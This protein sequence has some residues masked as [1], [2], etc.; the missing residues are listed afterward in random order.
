MEQSVEA[1][2]AK[3]TVATLGC[4]LVWV[5]GLVLVP[6]ARADSQVRIVRLSLVEGSVQIDRA[7]GQ[8]FEKAIMNMPLAQGMA[9]ATGDDSRAE[10]EFEDGSTLRLAPGTQVAFPQLG[11]RS[12]G[13][14]FTTVQVDQGLAYFN[15]RHKGDDDFRVGFVGREI[16]VNRNVHFRLDLA[17]GNPELAVFK[18]ELEVEGPQE[19]AKVKKN[20]TLTLDVSDFARSD[21][22]KSIVAE[23]YDSWDA[24]R[25]NYAAQYASNSYSRSPYYYGVSDL[26]YYGAWSTW[27]GY[28]VVWRPFGVGYG[29]DPFFNGAW[30][31][32]PGFG[33]TWVSTYPWGW[34][35]YRYGSWVYVTNYGWGWRPGGW[36]TWYTVP[37]VYNPPPFYHG[38]KPPPAVTI[39]TARPVAP[40]P[41]IIVDRGVGIIR[42]PRKFSDDFVPRTGV[43]T[44]RAPGVVAVPAAPLHRPPVRTITPAPGT[45]LAAPGSP[46]P[47]RHSDMRSRKVDQDFSPKWGARP[48]VQRS[49]PPVRTQPSAPSVQRS[50]PRMERS[51]PAP[52]MERSAPRM[53][54]SAPA[55]RITAPSGGRSGGG[56]ISR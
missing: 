45:G 53:E 47:M 36:R 55:P 5:A 17:S 19:H 39:V 21:L 14:R 29:W 28:G 13:A 22:A 50:A 9:I 31:W 56:R 10:V 35:P 42:G 25:L 54:R 52:R 7:T 11:L 23:S 44:R 41:T 46:M 48:G 12:S 26:N 20:E 40:P 3:R 4:V 30:A 51:A 2:M 34:T 32:Y 27:P 1:H 37:P 6:A 15:V 16:K 38:P 33:Y 18:G 8:G 43:N 49:A 24:D